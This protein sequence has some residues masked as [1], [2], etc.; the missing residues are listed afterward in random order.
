MDHLGADVPFEVKLHEG[1]EPGPGLV[2]G[3]RDHLALTVLRLLRV[4]VMIFELA[5]MFLGL[6]WVR[7]T[8]RSKLEER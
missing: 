5:L 1:E 2:M 7:I 3:V 6:F 8:K 4:Y